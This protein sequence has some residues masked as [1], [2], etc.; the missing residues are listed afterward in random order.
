MKLTDFGSFC[1]SRWIGHNSETFHKHYAQIHDQDLARACGI[2][3]NTV[4][5]VAPGQ[6]NPRKRLFAY[7]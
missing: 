6:K 7:G 1:E 3:A 2:L 4:Q 5:A